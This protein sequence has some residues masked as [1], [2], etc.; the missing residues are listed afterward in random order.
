[1]MDQNGVSV[2]KAFLYC[3]A[4]SV[5]L[6]ALLGIMS[7]LSGKWGWFEIRILLTTLIIGATS[8]CGLANAAYLAT[9]RGK[10]IPMAG[11]VGSAIGG[12]MLLFGVWGEFP[13]IEYW[14]CATVISIYSIAL[15][16]L[17]LLSMAKLA[18]MFQW[19]L[20][21]ANGVILGVATLIS[22]MI[23][24]ESHSFGM[25]QLLGVGAILDA[26]ITI[27]I[28]IFHKISRSHEPSPAGVSHPQ[29]L[30]EQEIRTLREKIE[31]LEKRK[32]EIG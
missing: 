14:K 5:G 23:L 24:G 28:P 16:H 19:S 8:I 11:T 13:S 4:I 17:S 18:E 12:A 15:A 1:M 22:I 20:W 29:D 6:G 3:L 2:R 31:S 26:A 7:I 30:I 21:V 9:G 27:L 32:R 25:F 10:L